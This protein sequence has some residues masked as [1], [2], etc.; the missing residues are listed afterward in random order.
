MVATP[1]PLSHHFHFNQ[2]KL[3]RR[4]CNINIFSFS[5]IFLS[6]FSL[7]TPLHLQMMSLIWSSIIPHPPK[8]FQPL[9]CTPELIP[10]TSHHEMSSFPFNFSV[11]TTNSNFLFLKTSHPLSLHI[12]S[13]GYAPS[14][15]PHKSLPFILPALPAFKLSFT[16][17]HSVNRSTSLPSV[18][19]P[20]DFPSIKKLRK[21]FVFATRL[22][23]LLFQILIALY[24]NH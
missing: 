24:G 6:F 9:I 16:I 20:N 7:H 17:S 11:K 14:I 23:S 10:L 12:S 21:Y 15:L 19:L 13:S 8:P 18:I 5:F 1:F 4:K 2:T 3:T 22:I